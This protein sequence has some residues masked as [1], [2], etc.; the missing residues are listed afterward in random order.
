MIWK[1]P[2]CTSTHMLRSQNSGNLQISITKKDSGEFAFSKYVHSSLLLWIFP[3]PRKG[4]NEF[5]YFSNHLLHITRIRWHVCWW[6]QELAQRIQD[7]RLWHVYNIH[8]SELHQTYS[9]DHRGYQKNVEQRLSKPIVLLLLLS[10]MSSGNLLTANSSQQMI[11]HNE[12]SLFFTNIN[13]LLSFHVSFY[14]YLY[15]YICQTCH[16]CACLVLEKGKK[17]QTFKRHPF[18]KLKNI[19]C[20]RFAILEIQNIPKKR[21]V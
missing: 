17:Y 16:L 6:Y 7:R 20:C 3:A 2:R 18:A 15:V 21:H 14:N 11:D 5:F 9:P 1:Y 19:W 12:L 13:L 4:P 8:K 10:L